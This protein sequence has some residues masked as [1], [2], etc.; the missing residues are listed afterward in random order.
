MRTVDRGRDDF[1]VAI[2]D[3]SRVDD[4]D[5]TA[6]AMLAGMGSALREH[7]KAGFIVDPDRVV[8][9]EGSEFEHIRYGTVDD[10]VTAAAAFV[11]G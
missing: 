7:G 2:L 9:P 8:I 5:D 6:R 10:A 4:I 11:H 3:V 1:A